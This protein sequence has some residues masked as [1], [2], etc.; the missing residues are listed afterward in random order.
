MRSSKIQQALLLLLVILS[1]AFV[2]VL[3]SASF[4][5]KIASFQPIGFE[6]EPDQGVWRVTQ[7][8]L[9]H[10]GLEQGDRILLVQGQQV[11]TAQ[12]IATLLRERPLSEL[13]VSR[14]VSLE[15][16]T[17][18]RPPA[19]IDF[20]YLALTAIAIL[21]LLIGLYTVF[22]EPR[23][24]A[25]IFFFFC[26]TS[27]ALFALGPRIVPQDDIDL[28]VFLVDQLARNLLP[29]LTVHLFLV[30]PGY[31]LERRRLLQVLPFVYLPSMGLFAFHLDQ[32]IGAPYFFGPP[33]AEHLARITTLEMVLFTLGGLAAAG[34]LCVR[35]IRGAEWEENRQSQWLLF[36]ML[37]GYLPFLLFSLLPWL[38]ARPLTGWVSLVAVVPLA[39]VP[40]AFSWAI[41]KYRL[42]DMGSILRDSLAYTL[43]GLVGLFAF[44]LVNLAIQSGVAEELTL[45]RNV[46]A[47]AAGLGIAGVLAPTRGAIAAGLDRLRLRGSMAHRQLLTGLGQDLLYERN[48]DTLCELLV[49]HLADALV[50]RIDLYLAQ[51]GSMVPAHPSPELPRDL[52]FSSFDAKLWTRDATSLS[53]VA[54]PGEGTSGVQRLFAKGH[55]YAFPMVVR[56]HRIGIAFLSYK[57]DEIP[58]DSEELDLVRGLL[59]QAALA[60][61]NAR[62]LEE[63]N[64]RLSE[65]TRLKDH[66]QGLL[67]SSPAGIVEL[68][69]T[70]HVRAANLA[71]AAIVDRPRPQLLDRP[72]AEILPVHLPS[73]GEVPLEVSFCEMS[74]RERHLHLQ[75]ASHR[76]QEGIR[77]L[78]VQDVSDKVALE[79]ALQEKERLASLGMLAAGVAHE[80]NTP[81]TGISSYAQM[82]M[83]DLEQDDPNRPLLKKMELQTHRASQIVNN[84]LDFA[85]NQRDQMLPV[86]W[87]AIIEESLL[88]LEERAADAGVTLQWQRPEKPVRVLGSEVELHQVVTNL[89]VNAIDALRGRDTPGRLEV[90]LE[91][92]GGKATLHLRDNGPGIAPERLET[93]FHPFHSGKIGQGGTGL[94]LA[95]TYNIVHR[96]GGVIRVENHSDGPGCTFTVQLPRATEA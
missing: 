50:C 14:G 17:Y 47:F 77:V 30:C 34:I 25:R 39:L 66:N 43:T 80:V 64:Q 18:A 59:N 45:A 37:G 15:T 49:E 86:T 6:V 1:T 72:M 74:G 24:T 7:V 31:L 22:K 42:L 92:E 73:P 29:A 71:F 95:I 12:Q 94:G 2:A 83:Q 51:G 69:D 90:S 28:L 52:P 41:L 60:I 62:L 4:S 89:A 19:N 56:G 35:L 5:R 84:L 88:V 3:G 16:L 61:E 40:L 21:Y 13:V 96:H 70:D 54:M 75:V 78:V 44:G 48:L 9:P 68:D 11:T 53:P 76:D 58:L 46:L 65:V 85:R 8:E 93:V 33:V 82:L 79:L 91:T 26:L 57:Y 10:L 67:E 32:V 36:G 87:D 38:M 20:P 27:A 55:R 81:L 63:V 23:G